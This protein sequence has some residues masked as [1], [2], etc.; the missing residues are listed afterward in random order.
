MKRSLMIG[1]CLGIAVWVHNGSTAFAEYSWINGTTGYNP[2]TSS[3]L[4]AAS[5][6]QTTSTPTDTS[7]NIAVPVYQPTAAET[8]SNFSIPVTNPA[9][10]DTWQ[11]IVD[12]VVNETIM[13]IAETPAAE[14]KCICT[15]ENDSDK[16]TQTMPWKKENLKWRA[17][18][19]STVKD[20]T[21]LNNDKCEGYNEK[22]ELK[23][24]D[25]LCE[26]DP[27]WSNL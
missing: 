15:C 22:N 9:P 20:C 23:K 18:V 3:S 26:K 1:A 25:F 16:L 27:V 19:E 7:Q 10:I 13:Y 11:Q 24:G 21:T 2:S 12:Q 17:K 8:Y 6:P 14:K 4:Y 5:A